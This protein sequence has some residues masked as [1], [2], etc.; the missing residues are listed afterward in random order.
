MFDRT[1]LG[2]CML[3]MSFFIFDP[4]N[5]IFSWQQGM[6]SC[7]SHKCGAK[8]FIHKS[9]QHMHGMTSSA[10]TKSPSLN[11]SCFILLI[12]II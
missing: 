9:I 12:Y 11:G 3:M 4:F 2:M 1:R 5:F 8:S 10:V 6:L 7:G